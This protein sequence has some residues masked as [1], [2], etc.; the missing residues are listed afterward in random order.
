MERKALTFLEKWY[1][2]ENSKPLILRGARQVGKSTL[3]HIFC[4]RHNIDLIELDFETVKLRQIENDTSFSIDKVIQEIEL[5]SRK[6]VMENSLIFFDEVQLQPKVINRLRYFYE[7]KPGLRIIAA[8]SL[9]EVTMEAARFSMPVGRVQ[10]YHLG[11]MTFSEF[12]MAKKENI[13][14]ERFN[15]IS[16]DDESDP[17]WLELGGNLLKE[18][19]YTGGMPEAVKCWSSGG[20]HEEVRDIQNSIIQTYRDDIP[21]YT[22][23]K[24]YARVMD[25]FDYTAANPG[26]K[27]VFSDVADTHSKNVKQAI[28]LLAKADIITKTTFNY[29]NGLPLSAGTKPS[30][31]KLFFLDIGLYNALNDTKWSDIFSLSSDKLLTKASMA[32]Q[33]VAQHLK[34]INSKQAAPELYYWLNNNRKG[35]AEIDLIYS[36]GGE[37]FPIEVKAGK[38]GK[39]KS[40]WKYIELKKPNYVVK[41]D[42]MERRNRISKISHKLPLSETE[43][44]SQLIGLP[45]FEIEK[46]DSYLENKKTVIKE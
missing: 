25:V 39:I 43:L 34:F 32:E 31:V 35:G 5:V 12:L 41:F 11:P 38:T 33:F 23:N 18:F 17:A 3:V 46:L 20:D 26:K 19:Y 21:K 7:K 44:T 22:L 36:H 28:N 9:L 24:E 29:C 16:L 2:K 37:I 4:K 42:L 13:F 27:V 40:L 10:Y 45:L 30:S 15:A 8:G 1:K 14:L 6:K